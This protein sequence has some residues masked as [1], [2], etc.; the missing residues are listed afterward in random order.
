MIGVGI[1]VGIASIFVTI[2]AIRQE[3][4]LPETETGV[5]EA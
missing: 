4:P 2:W 3:K 5:K 1:I